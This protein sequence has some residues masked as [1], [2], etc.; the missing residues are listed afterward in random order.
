MKVFLMFA[1]LN[2]ASLSSAQE[3]EPLSDTLAPPFSEYTSYQYDSLLQVNL[4]IYNYNSDLDDDRTSDSIRF[5]SNGGAHAYYH[6]EIKL[7]GSGQWM[8][9]QTFYIDMPYL[10]NTVE[11]MTQF[12]VSDFDGDGIDEVYLN[13][14]NAFGYIPNSLEYK[15]LNSKKLLL[16]YEDGELHVKN[17]ACKTCHTKHMD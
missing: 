17:F 14:D 4:L 8:K 15:D 1:F 9:Y 12:A 10:S 11:E 2:Y 7:S 13:I 6:L 3:Q 16:D 5:I